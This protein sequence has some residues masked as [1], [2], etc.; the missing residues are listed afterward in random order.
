M[1]VESQLCQQDSVTPSETGVIKWA[2]R[3]LIPVDNQAIKPLD[4]VSHPDWD[5]ILPIQV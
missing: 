2:I 5:L 3:K 4:L 1:A